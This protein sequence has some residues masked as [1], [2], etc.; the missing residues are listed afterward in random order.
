MATV[1]CAIA[2]V[3]SMIAVAVGGI[4]LICQRWAQGTREPTEA[5]A[6]C[7]REAPMRS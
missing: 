1:F 5:V 4:G 2:A 7:E 3:A 6:G